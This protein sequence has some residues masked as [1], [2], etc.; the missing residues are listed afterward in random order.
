MAIDPSQYVVLDVETNGLSS[1]RDDLLSVSIFMPDTGKEYDR[2]LPLELQDEILTT[3]YNGI[4]EETLVG[5]TALTQSELNSLIAEFELDRR[6][7]LHYGNIDEKFI[8]NYLKRHKLKG[9]GL[10]KFY[11]YKRDIISSS[12]SGGNVTKDNLCNVFGI[13]GVKAVHSGINDCKLEWALFNA[14]NNKK[15]LVTGLDVYEFNT[16][17]M[18][19][20]SYIQGFPNFKYVVLNLPKIKVTT[21]PIYEFQLK[22]RKINK[23]DTNISGMTVEHLINRMLEV[24]KQDSRVFTIQNKSK[25][26]H[27]GKLPS[28]FNDMP[29]IFNNDGSITATREQDEDYVERVNKT[30]SVI[31]KEI[32]PLIDYIRSEI[33]QGQTI[34]SQELV[35]HPEN[36]CF[37]LCDLSNDSCV[38]VIKTSFSFDADKFKYQLFYQANGRDCYTMHI[39]WAMF[40]KKQNKKFIISKVNFTTR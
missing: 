21:T 15:L 6:T 16:D 13:S 11:N 40:D 18:V 9:F 35:L 8:K 7:I 25:L 36:N 22:S 28:A 19:P 29:V 20:V 30:I 38:L 3:Q 31:R 4:T 37:A 17:Y 5:A 39:D 12:F 34:R 32:T 10:M 2:Y 33:F 1:L 27:L 23:F 26:K 14:M 24:E